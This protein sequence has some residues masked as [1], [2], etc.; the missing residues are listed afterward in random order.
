MQWPTPRSSLK[1][2]A[3]KKKTGKQLGFYYRNNAT[4]WMTTVL[5][6]EWLTDW[7]KKLRDQR[8][9]VVLLQDDFSGHVVPDN[10]TNIEVMNFSPNLTSHVQPADAGIIRAFKAHYRC[11]YM[12]RA[13]DRYDEGLSPAIIYDIDQLEAMRLADL[14]WDTVKQSTIRNCWVKSGILP[15]PPTRGD[16]ASPETAPAPAEEPAAS[17]ETELVEVLDQMQSRGIIQRSNRVDLEDLVNHP[18]E[19]ILIDL[20]T[21][22]ELKEAALSRRANEQDMDINGGDNGNEESISLVPTRRDALAAAS[23]LRLFV[24][25]NEGEFSRKLEV[26]LASFGRNTRLEETYSLQDTEI[27]QYF[28]PL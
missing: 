9:K 10:L 6:Q 7:D 2:R 20:T 8:R 28:K 22:E 14:A 17:A 16:T 27:T 25:H 21:D 13:L 23:T 24:H 12:E 5:Y 3:F 4:A 18:G 26:L 11:L 19:Q 1:P 15:D